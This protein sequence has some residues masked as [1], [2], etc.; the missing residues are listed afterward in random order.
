MCG[1]KLNKKKEKWKLRELLGLG[2]VGLMIK[3]SRL[4]WFEYGERIDDNDWVKRCMTWEA[5][6]IR[7]DARKT[8][9]GIVLRM[10]W[11]I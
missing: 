7:K 5:D 1:V 9:G 4:R 10:T 8:H 2:T 11:K 3:K 6:G